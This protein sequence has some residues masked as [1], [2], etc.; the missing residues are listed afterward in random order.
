MTVGWSATS[1]MGRVLSCLVAVY[2]GRNP[3]LKAILLLAHLDVVE[4]ALLRIPR[5]GE[6]LRSRHSN[7]GFLDLAGNGHPIP[8]ADAHQAIDA[9]TMSRGDAESSAR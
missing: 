7:V 9:H 6:H 8:T 5:F 4:A 1:P 3:K 2:P